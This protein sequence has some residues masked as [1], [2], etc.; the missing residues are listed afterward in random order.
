MPEG[1]ADEPVTLLSSDEDEP[2]AMP[3]GR[4]GGAGAG[5]AADFEWPGGDI[6]A[7]RRTKRHSAHK[8]P[9]E[10]FKVFTSSQLLWI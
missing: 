3:A 6:E 10:R 5:P 9:S 7:P 8:S 4:G 1:N 2:M